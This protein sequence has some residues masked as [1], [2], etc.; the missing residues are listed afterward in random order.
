M[1]KG[2]ISIIVLCFL[3]FVASAL[4]AQEPLAMSY[5]QT[6]VSRT[7]GIEKIV[8][9]TVWVKEEKLRMEQFLEGQ[10]VIILISDGTTYLYYPAFNMAL[11]TE[12][13][14][15]VRQSGKYLKEIVEY[16]EDTKANLW[17]QEQ[18][19]G[20]LC[21]IYQII[22]PQMEIKSTVWIWKERNLP[23]KLVVVDNTK[24]VTTYYS[25]IRTGINIPDTYFSPPPETCIIDITQMIPAF[26]KW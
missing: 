19:N 14:I 23:M 17:G 8:V 11:K 9:S 20:H 3:G 22:D 15:T 21:D 12:T 6:V 7:R 5:E 4:F 25:N 26:P 18:V 13:N 2:L 1:R 10:E 24:T 16:I